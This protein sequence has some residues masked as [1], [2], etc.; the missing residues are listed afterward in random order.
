MTVTIEPKRAT[1]HVSV[2]TS[3]STGALPWAY[4]EENRPVSFCHDGEGAWRRNEPP[5]I[6]K[7]LGDQSSLPV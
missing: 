2:S 5:E 4:L 1:N 6:S 3:A 7:N